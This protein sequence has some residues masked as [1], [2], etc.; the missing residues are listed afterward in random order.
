[1]NN[2]FDPLF[3]LLLSG[4]GVRRRLRFFFLA[5]LE[6]KTLFLVEPATQ[7]DQPAPIAAERHRGARLGRELSVT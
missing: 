7:V 6:G 1:M 3:S 5:E 4:V 2:S